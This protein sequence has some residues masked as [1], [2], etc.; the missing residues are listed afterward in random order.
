MA[1]EKD[2]TAE[3]RTS[4]VALMVALT[5]MG[6]AVDTADFG[7]AFWKVQQ[8]SE[9]TKRLRAA[10]ENPVRIAR[11]IYRSFDE[12]ASASG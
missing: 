6:K 11:T 10:M 8:A 12:L 9:H 1:N 4:L 7:H 5:D 2:L 3:Y